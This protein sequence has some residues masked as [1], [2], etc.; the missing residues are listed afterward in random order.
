[1]ANSYRRERI[2]NCKQNIEEIRSN[3]IKK[4][5]AA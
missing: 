1:M 3:Q 2:E 4:G 5:N